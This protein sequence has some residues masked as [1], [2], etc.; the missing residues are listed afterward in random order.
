MP[1]S[2][3]TNEKIAQ[4]NSNQYITLG[5]LNS[6]QNIDILELNTYKKTAIFQFKEPLSFG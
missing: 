4:K 2:H 5:T 3:Q 6:K 1:Q